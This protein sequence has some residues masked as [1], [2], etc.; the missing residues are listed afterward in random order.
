M[1]LVE[2][3]SAFQVLP[4]P[5]ATTTRTSPLYSAP[6][7]SP[8]FN[9]DAPDLDSSDPFRVLGLTRNTVS[10]VLPH[11]TLVTPTGVNMDKI[12]AAYHRLATMY[13]PD[14]VLDKNMEEVGESAEAIKKAASD[15]FA[16]INWAYH[17]ITG[18]TRDDE[19]SRPK[20]STMNSRF[21]SFKKMKPTS[22]SGPSYGPP[23]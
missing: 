9:R 20:I 5:A 7:W 4:L 2:A 8:E 19:F 1:I 23:F 11:T 18:K 10:D 22:L 15:Q 13:H 16:K 12:K 3:C 6:P 21:S 17:V 14:S